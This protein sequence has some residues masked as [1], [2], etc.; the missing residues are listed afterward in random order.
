M[1][2]FFKTDSYV[3]GSQQFNLRI[4]D[5]KQLYVQVDGGHVQNSTHR[6]NMRIIAHQNSF[7]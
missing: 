7:H 1:G 3:C 2:D 4:G 5:I 6:S